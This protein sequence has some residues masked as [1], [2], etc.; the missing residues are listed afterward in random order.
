LS[1]KFMDL[2]QQFS[3]TKLGNKPGP[4]LA[5]TLL[6]GFLSRELAGAS[7]LELS[8]E[9]NPGSEAEGAKEWSEEERIEDA[10]QSRF[11]EA[12]MLRLGSGLCPQGALL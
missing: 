5:Q 8:G 10:A 2:N 7:D 3:S 6:G 1:Q 9:E 11:I 4:S 12:I